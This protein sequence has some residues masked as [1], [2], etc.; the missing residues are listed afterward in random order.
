MITGPTHGAG[1][2]TYGRAQRYDGYCRA[3]A[4]CNHNAD[5]ALVVEGTF[6]YESGREAMKR[7]LALRAPPDAVFAANDMMALGAMSVVREAGLRVPDDVALVGFDDV[8][9]T[10]LTS[11]ALTT[12]AMPMSALGDSAANLIAEQL[13]L[14]GDHTPVRKM[15]SAELIVRASS[16]RG[17][18]S[19][20]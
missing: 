20:A 5:P 11:P 13:P 17:A 10:G 15:F 19:L 18:A 2:E 8:P 1:S 7:L 16:M 6:R 4:T 14:A 9:M 12:M 3:L